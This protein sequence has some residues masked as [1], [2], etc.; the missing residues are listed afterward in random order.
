LARAGFPVGNVN[1][2]PANNLAEVTDMNAIR[3]LPD[4]ETISI[5]ELNDDSPFHE[6]VQSSSL[7]RLRMLS[8]VA[9]ALE[10]LIVQAGDEPELHVIRA[11][12]V[13]QLSDLRQTMAEIIH[14]PLR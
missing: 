5:D 12:A 8:N 13:C 2:N 9:Q 3:A 7:E 11:F 14:G 6:T 1:E 4:V 10:N